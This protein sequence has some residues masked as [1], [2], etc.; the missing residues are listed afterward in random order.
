MCSAPDKQLQP[1]SRLR[2]TPAFKAGCLNRVQQKEGEKRGKGREACA[3][4]VAN[5]AV[6]SALRSENKTHDEKREDANIL[7]DFSV[8]NFSH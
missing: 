2:I 8:K 7:Q 4:P 1:G 6:A 3:L 5:T